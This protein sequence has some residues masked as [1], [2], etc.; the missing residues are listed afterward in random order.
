LIEYSQTLRKHCIRKSSLDSQAVTFIQTM[1]YL[2]LIMAVIIYAPIMLP[3]VYED[4]Y[5]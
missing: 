1:S 2:T 4:F 5:A 3:T